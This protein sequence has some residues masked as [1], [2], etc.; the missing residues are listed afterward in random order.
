MVCITICAFHLFC[1]FNFDLQDD[2]AIEVIP[3]ELLYCGQLEQLDL[4]SNQLFSL[5]ADL[6]HLGSLVDL[7]VSHNCLTE[8]PN[9]IGLLLTYNNPQ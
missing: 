8:F 4:S 1:R 7:T 9:S 5:P 2:N 6:G 3:E